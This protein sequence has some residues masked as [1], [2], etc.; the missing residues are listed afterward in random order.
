MGKFAGLI[1]SK[2][3]QKSGG[4]FADLLESRPI[5]SPKE[6]EN[7]IK[8]IV[9]MSESTGVDV[10]GINENY[11]EF[12]KP[13]VKRNIYASA[14][15]GGF[16]PHITKETIPGRFISGTIQD[17]LD[18]TNAT[19][20][21]GD[22]QL[23]GQDI[24]QA[25]ENWQK[26]TQK[27]QISGQLRESITDPLTGIVLKNVRVAAPMIKSLWEAVP[28]TTVGMGIGAG[29][30][31]AVGQ[32]PPLTLSPFEDLP[33]AAAGAI[34]GGGAG[35]TA[36][37]ATFWY[38]HGV[39][40]FYGEMLQSNVDPKVAGIVA[41]IA[42]IPYAAI[43]FA[44]MK[45][46]SP[47]ARAGL[48]QIINRSVT[49]VLAEAA[50]KHATIVG[51]EVLEE[52]G[53]EVVKIT[54]VE[55]ARYF[56]DLDVKFD[57]DSW[58]DRAM[59]VL[60]TGIESTKSMVLLP[61]P[62]TVVDIASGLPSTVPSGASTVEQ[63]NQNYDKRIEE[64]TPEKA[65]VLETLK[66]TEIE[67]LTGPEEAAEKPT[68]AAEAKEA[69]EPTIT[70]VKGEVFLH[71]TTEK[72]LAGILAEGVDPDTIDPIT[73]Q[74]GIAFFMTRDAKEAA[75]HGNKLVEVQL[76]PTAKIAR[77]NNLQGDFFSE[78]AGEQE[79]NVEDVVS[80][81]KEQGF[82]VVDMEAFH[83][84]TNE[85]KSELTVLNPAVIESIKQ[86]EPQ[87][88][89][90]KVAE[91]EGGVDF[92][93]TVEPTSSTPT[94]EGYVYHATNVENAQDIA[95]SGEI[96]IHEPDFGTDQTVWPD[97]AIE[98][99]AYFSDSAGNVWQFAPEEGKPAILRIKKNAAKF[100]KESTGDV[101][102]TE[103]IPSNA[104][105]ILTED[106]W[107]PLT[108]AKVAEVEGEVVRA[109]G[110]GERAAEALE[111]VKA[112]SR[113]DS[114]Y[115]GMTKDEY[116]AT[117]GK[118]GGVISR[119][120]FRAAEEGTNF[121]EE[122]ADAESFIDFG[123]DD[124]RKTGKP[125][126]IV[127]VKKGD[128]LTK[129]RRGDYEAK[130]EIPSE[131]IGRV[132]EINAVG[133][134]LIATPLTPTPQAKAKPVVK[135]E[136]AEPSGGV[137]WQQ[138]MKS[139]LDLA[140]KDRPLIVAEQ[141]K[142]RGERVGA[143]VGTMDWLRKKGV[144]GKEAIHKSAGKLKGALADYEG[145]YQ[146]LSQI[147]KPATIEAAENDMADSDTLTPF[148]KISLTNHEGTGAWDKM[149]RGAAMTPGDVNLIRKWQPLLAKEAAKRVPLSSRIW[150]G[151]EWMLGT[152]KFGAAFDVQIRRQARWLRG[153]HPVLF[154]KAVGRDL[155]AYVSNEYAN[156][157][158]KETVASPY[159][160]QAQRN[161]LKFLTRQPKSSEQRPEQFVS[162]LPETLPWLGK[163][164]GTGYKYTGGQVGKVYAAS[165]RGFIDSFNWMQQK[166][167]DMQIEKW[168]AQNVKITPKM[169]NDLVDF[170]NTMLGMS[171]PKTNFGGA[172]NRVMRP[173]MWSPSL[174]WSRIRTPSMMLS[175]STMRGEVAASLSTYIGTGLMYLAAA[176]LL[177]KWWNKEDPVEWDI[178]SSDFG[179]I[180]IGD[181]RWDVYGDGG[182]YIRA[183]LQAWAGTKKNQAGRV[184]TKEGFDKLDPFKQLLRNKRA[185][186]LDLFAKVWSGRNYYGGDAWALPDYDEMRKEGGTKEWFAD[187]H[188]DQME[189]KGKEV[190]FFIGKEVYDR[191]MPFFIQGSLEAAWNDGWPQALGAGTDEFFSGQALSYK[192]STNSELQMV[193]DIAAT[194]E[195]DKV[196]DEL[197][198]K[199][200]EKLYKQVPEMGELEMKKSAEKLPPEEISLT[201]QNRAA[202]RIFRA[203][204]DE[205]KK[206]MNAIGVK[207]SAPS[208]KIGKFFLNESRYTAYEE[209]TRQEIEKQL[210]KK[211]NTGRY[212]KM[213]R[214]KRM[215]ELKE[216]ISDAKADARK[217]LLKEI[218]AGKI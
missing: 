78:V 18:A 104:V 181:T 163:R 111:N 29:I 106:G 74:K 38:R 27:A 43:E 126:Y 208:R 93:R 202:K 64:A 156:K 206:E 80:A 31:L 82:D 145:R 108:P 189:D 144:S 55:V 49:G 210:S 188:E 15:M 170:Q 71:G 8:D 90:A 17:S 159:H 204:P 143:M 213:D 165:M 135:K 196:W 94:E 193:Q 192:P 217:R 115:R 77:P 113:E 84:L 146:P 37:M 32:V 184:A 14:G 4:A 2:E 7:Q 198:P 40:E 11:E 92:T 60:D 22:A 162:N 28:A 12:R 20:D 109:E 148:D 128:N 98:G 155:A 136:G 88:T 137:S 45:A 153:R 70:P 91:V 33:L 101:Y 161:G 102:S 215:K 65:E 110:V 34:K 218:N 166:M 23:N 48:R 187:W 118:G 69:P 53:Q 21:L 173:I 125:T 99:R 57:L 50:K 112:L 186:A 207:I 76:K 85:P 164:I 149:L 190:G 72:G 169:L 203:M 179:K 41:P 141:K 35:M 3:Q 140:E 117:I 147:L 24:G 116:D 46:L 191:Y 201:K 158:A 10:A 30:G 152:L 197:T 132:W 39:G 67:Q 214:A 51:V 120:D 200:Q 195:Y 66:K 87:L 133:D 114:V 97:G 123:R 168:K 177:A 52:M 61:L 83:A 13:K 56:S 47:A 58:K 134:E 73:K 176:S 100:K 107:K 95:E 121:A 209:Y 129:T 157:M 96:S 131:Q 119:G 9:K 167:W 105:E 5:L 62:G 142:T 6:E 151:L 81:A 63:V 89:P 172:V 194:Q 42:A 139:V 183:M 124:P 79:F 175:N 68:E 26:A 212:K 1:E 25:Y 127:E 185:P 59:R 182:P 150:S 216:D 16:S 205:V 103:A 36:S 138:A 75:F 211:I 19:L 160:E 178:N 154:T 174:T 54:G 199:Q 86:V 180:R 122:F 44:Q 130:T 171:K